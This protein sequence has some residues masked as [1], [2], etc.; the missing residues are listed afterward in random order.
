MQ[1]LLP[2]SETSGLKCVEWQ[3]ELLMMM[4]LLLRRIGAEHDSL[5]LGAR[6]GARYREHRAALVQG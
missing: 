2:P 5:H 1:I 4:P 6:A 3:R